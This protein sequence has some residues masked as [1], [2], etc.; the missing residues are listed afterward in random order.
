MD[1]GHLHRFPCLPTRQVG[2][3]ECNHT[4]GVQEGLRVLT[5][6]PHW[7]GWDPGF[8]CAQH[9][10]RRP[11]P[12][13]PWSANADGMD[14]SRLPGHCL[15]RCPVRP[16]LKHR[17]SS[18]GSWERVGGPGGGVREKATLFDRWCTAT[19]TT[20]FSFFEN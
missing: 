10:V 2:A 14:T 18:R 1:A 15:A 12:A 11:A 7:E 17:R 20:D 4:A 6:Y 3:K 16:Q 19:K 9:V 8:W 13:R 5:P